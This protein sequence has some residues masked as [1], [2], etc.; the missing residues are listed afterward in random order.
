MAA[1]SKS[2]EQQARSK[3]LSFRLRIGLA[4]ALMMMVLLGGR[5]FQVQGLDM[6]GH[7]QEAVSERLRTVPLPAE[8]G[9]ILDTEGRVMASSV[10]R[11]DIVVDPRLTEDYTVYDEDSGL[12]LPITVRETAEELARILES[13]ADDIEERMTRDPEEYHWVPLARSVTPEQRSQVMELQAPGISAEPQSARTYPAGPVAGSIVGF[14]GSDGPLEG[15]EAVHDEQLTGEDGER[16]YEVG[17]DGV[18]IPTATYEDLPAEDGQDVRLTID[19]DLQ[20]FAQ[21]SIASKANTYNAQWGNATVVDLREG[22][23]GEILAMADSGL[24]D[25]S[26]PGE[27]DELFRTPLALAQSFEPGSVGKTITFAAALEEGV[28]D[29]ESSFSVGDRHTVDGETI[30]N[31]TRHEQFDMTTAGIYARSYNTGTVMIGD[32]LSEQQRYDWMQKAGLGQPIDIGLGIEGQGTL[33][34]PEEWDNRQPL[35]TQF[36]QG[37]ETTVLHNV[38][39]HA[40]LATDGVNHPL[41]IVDSYVDPDGTEHPVETEAERVFS[42]ETSEDMLRLMEGVVDYGTGQGAQI[43]GYRVGGKTGTAQAAGEGGGFDGYTISFVGV[44]PVEDPQFLTSITIHRPSGQYGDWDLSD[45]F[46]EIM[47][48]T[49]SS[50]EVPPTDD[51]SG[52]YDGFVGERQDYPW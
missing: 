25:P 50:Y 49:L 28:V 26:A 51:E 12:R 45:T 10:E 37:Y 23:E 39:M 13:D 47:E 15:V 7:A 2:T 29:P 30:Q 8:R 20:W 44:A 17:A 21:E 31:A 24:V 19:Q 9:D 5:L 46:Q 14:V 22:S 41:R 27:A 4:V 35:S 43:E 48:H 33:R 42:S 16:I 34:P 3:R 6:D 32:E 18:R 52:A 36:G 38:Q 11:Y 1:Q 40:M